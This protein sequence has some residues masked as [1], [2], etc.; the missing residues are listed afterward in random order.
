MYHSF[1]PFPDVFYGLF[2]RRIHGVNLTAL[3]SFPF[4]LYAQRIIELILLWRQWAFYLCINIMKKVIHSISQQRRIPYTVLIFHLF[5]LWTL[6]SVVLKEPISKTDVQPNKQ[7]A[8][9]HFGCSRQCRQHSRGLK[10][11]PEQK[12]LEPRH[13]PAKISQVNIKGGGRQSVL[14]RHIKVEQK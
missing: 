10:N 4:W 8:S 5:N 13:W 3:G 7:C 1:S 9:R 12:V 2:A 14:Y 11:K 6:L